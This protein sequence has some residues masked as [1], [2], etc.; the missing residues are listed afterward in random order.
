MR[1][2]RLLLTTLIGAILVPIGVS[3][4]ASHIDKRLSESPVFQIFIVFA[5]LLAILVA[6][7]IESYPGKTHLQKQ[8]RIFMPA[9]ELN[10]EAVG[11]EVAERG[12]EL[13]DKTRRPYTREH[14][15]P[16]QAVPFEDRHKPEPTRTFDERELLTILEEGRG[17]LLIGPPLEGKSRTLLE[18]IRRLEHFVVVAPG[19][20]MP[21]AEAIELLRGKRVVC[22]FDDMNGH[23]DGGNMWHQF[24]AQITQVAASCAIAAACRDGPELKALDVAI[25]TSSLQRL[26][27]GI[28]YR[29]V[30]VSATEAQKETLRTA[31]GAPSGH[32][33]ASL[34]EVCMSDALEV[35][36]RRAASLS[37][38]AKDCL[39]AAQLISAAGIGRLT[40]TRIRCILQHVFCRPLDDR[41]VIDAVRELA[42][43]AF[44]QSPPLA[45]PIE[46]VVAYVAGPLAPRTY[47]DGLS[48]PSGD[49]R[50]LLDGLWTDGDLE[51]LNNVAHSA[52]HQ[53]APNLALG[54]WHRI[55]STTRSDSDRVNQTHM[56]Q[57]LRDYGAA[58]L[59]LSQL[60]ESLKILRRVKCAEPS[61]SNCHTDCVYASSQILISKI[62]TDQGK[63]DD[64]AT[65]LDS[66]KAALQRHIADRDDG[67]RAGSAYLLTLIA[68]S[69]QRLGNFSKA[70]ISFEEVQRNFAKDSAPLV[71]SIALGALVSSAHVSIQ[72][73]RLD[74]AIDTYKSAI[75]QF[76]S[77][78]RV[79]IQ[80][81]IARA[82]INTGGVREKK[83]EWPLALEC[84][85]QVEERYSKGTSASLIFHRAQAMYDAGVALRELGRNEEAF[86]RW[87]ET[88]RKF[89]TSKESRARGFAVKSL[90]AAAHLW[91]QLG[92]TKRAFEVY[93][94]IKK[95][96]A[97]DRAHE[98][99]CELLESIIS[100]AELHFRVRQFEESVDQ[101]RV[102][103]QLANES[104]N[105]I[106]Y[107]IG[108]KAQITLSRVYMN[109]KNYLHAWLTL[110]EMT[111]RVRFFQDP[112]VG[113]IL[114]DGFIALNVAK[115][116][117]DRSG[118][119]R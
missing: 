32:I 41:G 71:Q 79:E 10:P 59:S 65:A 83:N 24:Y 11:F 30:L 61:G 2:K 118:G 64:A 75:D 25:Q 108:L 19:L 82:I 48:G 102:A 119:L 81:E 29:L 58:L 96:F 54:I 93:D 1:S 90:S 47:R 50:A 40:R 42:S 6:W 84:Y 74:D 117:L 97:G 36:Y 106:E 91:G 33:F 31:I 53:P 111:S 12:A 115:E 99:R 60:S 62:L 85:E 23:S 3:L 63:P 88:R 27:E 21:S 105:A 35:M 37:Q 4:L 34:G 8:F 107:A 44:F 80:A 70:T 45:D 28:R 112:Q 116:A 26:I 52:W 92:N 15:I 72:Q 43:S 86:A 98:V 46:P 78:E 87:T 7:W 51:A 22:L 73:G 69:Y 57:C 55:S 76:A 9:P 101:L 100:R 109:T 104:E 18:L 49:L 66:A 89:G 13:V 14:Y 17:L 95:E 113:R 114:G 16:R 39:W 94:E 20:E 77:S 110:T 67:I 68:S 38:P 103:K 56:G 5:V